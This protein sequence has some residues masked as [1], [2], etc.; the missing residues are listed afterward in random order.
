MPGILR[1]VITAA[2]RCDRQRRERG[3]AA[4]GGAHAIAGRRQPQ[5]DQLQQIGVVVDEQDVACVGHR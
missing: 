4:V 5:A 1:S 3:F 2:G